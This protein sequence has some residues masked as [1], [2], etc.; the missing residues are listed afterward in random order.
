MRCRFRNP[1][2]RLAV[3]LGVALAPRAGATAEPAPLPAVL[4]L[5]QALSLFRTQGLDLLIAD[6]A[7]EAAQGDLASAGAVPNPSLTATLGKS[8]VCTDGC[9][10][11]PPP[12]FTVGLGDQNAIEDSLSG[13]RGLRLEVARAA[14]QVARLQRVDAERTGTALVK[15]QFIQVLI[16]Q[17]GLVTAQDTARDL[18]RLRELTAVRYRSGAVSEADL[19]RVETDALE[20]EQAVSTARLQLRAAQLGLAFLLGIRSQVPEFRVEASELLVA[21][22]PPTLTEASPASLLA[23]AFETRPDLGAARAQMARA[24][25]SVRLAQRLVFPDIALNVNYAQQGTSPAAVTPP[26]VTLGLTFTL[27]L[28]YQQQGEIR[29]AQ[30]D[31]R[32][33]ELGAAKA[34]AQVVSD[35]EGAYA[36]FQVALERERRMEGEAGLLARARRARDLVGVQYQKGAASLLELLDAQRTFRTVAFEARS[37][38]ADYW[39]SVFRLEQAVGRTLL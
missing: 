9:S 18:A 12:A 39:S 19:A 6:A 22:V 21:S 17:E 24:D 2:W 34:R 31:A 37:N 5:D 20:A 32:T 38:L 15:L 3:A 1:A 36:G 29:R 11:I 28:F 4:G 8:F 35:V 30:A 14:L 23:Q 10:F 16:G 7:L 33:Q 27:P 26:T 13:K 25:A